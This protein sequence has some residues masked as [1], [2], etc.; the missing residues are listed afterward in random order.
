MSNLLATVGSV[1]VI[2]TGGPPRPPLP[3][4]AARSRETAPAPGSSTATVPETR[5]VAR[6]AAEAQGRYQIR[7]HT[8]TLRI[9]TEIVDMDTGDV[10]MYL[11]AG[12]RPNAAPLRSS[13]DDGP[14]S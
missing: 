11:P 2:A 13:G 6:Q 5:A 3:G 1:A 7:I 10:L 4:E 9:I 12:Y 8:D 14:A